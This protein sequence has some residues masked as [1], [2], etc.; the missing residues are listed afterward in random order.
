MRMKGV[1]SLAPIVVFS[2]LAAFVA[3]QTPGEGSPVSS[4]V[5]QEIRAIL[6]LKEAGIDLTHEGTGRIE[7]RYSFALKSPEIKQHEKGYVEFDTEVEYISSLLVSTRLREA[8]RVDNPPPIPEK[9]LRE[10]T[11]LIRGR[12]SFDW[13]RLE[14]N[15]VRVVGQRIW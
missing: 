10:A 6:V 5:E 15:D 14:M 3:A 13:D 11:S 12:E 1:P 2:L 8:E 4:Q 9:V 7:E